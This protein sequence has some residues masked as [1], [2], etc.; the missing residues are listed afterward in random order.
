LINKGSEDGIL[1]KM[2]VITQQKSLVGKISEVYK[3]FSKVMLVSNKKCAF[4]A[5]IQEKN[6]SGLVK[7]KGNFKILLD[8]VPQN[9][10]ISQEDIVITSSLGGLFPAGLLVGQIE[11]VKKSDIEPFQQ[12]KIKPIFN[13]KEIN[14]LF[15]ITEY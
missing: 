5:K 6:I 1:E 14:F 9:E 10:K 15:V 13:I 12:V 2:P 4:D 3:N 8:F 11:E 7:G